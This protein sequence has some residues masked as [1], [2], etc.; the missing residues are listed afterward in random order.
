VTSLHRDFLQFRGLFPADAHP[1]VELHLDRTIGLFL[2]LFLFARFL[3]MIAISEVKGGS[4][5]KNSRSLRNGGAQLMPQ[6][7]STRLKINSACG[8]DKRLRRD[9]RISDP[10]TWCTPGARF[11][12]WAI[13]RSD[14]LSPSRCRIERGNRIPLF[15]LGGCDL[16]RLRGSATRSC[17]QWWS[18]PLNYPW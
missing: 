17:M 7:I 5:S 12:R 10:Q 1:V 18:A 3:P 16:H 2:T 11:A 14:A 6:S 15:E 4:R 8:E 9:G 13:P